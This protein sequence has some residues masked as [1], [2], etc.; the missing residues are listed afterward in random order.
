M[1]ATKILT[2]NKITI[3]REQ[4]FEF[5]KNKKD[6]DDNISSSTQHYLNYFDR[7][8]ATNKI[9]NWNWV[10]FIPLWFFYRKMYLNGFGVIAISRILDILGNTAS[11]KLSLGLWGDYIDIGLA[12]GFCA[13][14]MIYSDWIY[15]SY[16]EKKI[17]KG[18]LKSGT[19]LI[20]VIIFAVIIILLGLLILAK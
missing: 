18:T 8:Q 9:G 12:L 17:S 7:Y 13:L 4:F 10:A 5:I 1:E 14:C 20:P 3:T 16:A 15:L 11:Q 2:Q 19:S 6:T